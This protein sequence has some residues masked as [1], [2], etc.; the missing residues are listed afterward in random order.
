MTRPDLPDLEAALRAALAEE[1]DGIRPSA[2]L[3]AI[4]DAVAA[5][6]IPRSSRAR[7]WVLSAATAA[8][9]VGL[10]AA[11]VHQWQR[12]PE[13]LR[14]G[15][16]GQTS[17]AVGATQPPASTRTATPP[18]LPVYY[19]G[20]AS[21]ADGDY[22][23]FRTFLTPSADDGNSREARVRD[24]VGRSLAFGIPFTND[25]PTVWSHTRVTD[26]AVTPDLIT[27]TLSDGGNT[28]GTAPG[29]PGTPEGMARLGIQQLVWTAQAA[30][31]QGRVPVTFRLTDGS[32][33]L[34][35]RYAAA[36][37]YDRPDTERIGTE[38]A[39]VWIDAPGFE[40]TLA[41]GTPVTARGL[42]LLDPAG[43][44][45]IVKTP[46]GTEMGRGRVVG[47]ASTSTDPTGLPAHA[48]TAALGMLP[49]GSYH[50][51]VVAD[52]GAGAGTSFTIG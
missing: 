36:D 6:E 21:E 51:W 10:V 13:S 29:S 35:G 31:G 43:L 7:S 1:A 41:A 9:A 2:R 39:P 4:R 52:S 27:L 47:V 3:E 48:Y 50:L 49:E 30:A 46:D 33:L 19:I 14:P 32:S 42:T 34:F 44:T 37:R 45:W 11:G 17:S 38:V 40:A 16:G 24:A 22:R 23:L 25:G 12:P 28:G 5:Q 20:L 15:S 26:V 8:A 18:A